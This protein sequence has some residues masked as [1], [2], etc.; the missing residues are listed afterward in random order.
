MLWRRHFSLNSY[1][2]QNPADLGAAVILNGGLHRDR[3]AR[4]PAEKV[5]TRQV[6]KQLRLLSIFVVN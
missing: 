6:A 4:E 3:K 5:R 2:P 1:A